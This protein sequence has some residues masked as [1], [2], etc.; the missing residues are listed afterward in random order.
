MAAWLILLFLALSVP[1]SAQ[2]APSPAELAAYRGLHAAAAKD[3]AAEIE[4]LVKAGAAIDTRD[5]Y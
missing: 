4:K 3:D 2:M 1:A 5:G